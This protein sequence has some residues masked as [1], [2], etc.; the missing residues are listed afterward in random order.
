MD[1]DE[2]PGTL[3]DAEASADS[4]ASTAPGS[5]EEKEFKVIGF[6]KILLRLIIKHTHTH[7]RSH[8]S[9]QTECVGAERIRT[10]GQIH[11]HLHWAETT[12]LAHLWEA[13]PQGR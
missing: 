7:T 13:R 5:A 10:R 2:E 12:Y 3:P 4:A 6:N 1:S 8:L 11:F 9:R